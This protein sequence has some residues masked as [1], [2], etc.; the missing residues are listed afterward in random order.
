MEQAIDGGFAAP[1]FDAQAIFRAVMDAMA[2]PGTIQPV[3]ALTQPPATLSATAGAVALTLCDHDTPLWLDTPL[4][5]SA[6]AKSWLAF[7]SGAPL[8]AT[9]ADAHFA[10]VANPANL[11]ALENFAQGTQEYPD[12]STTLILQVESLT[13]GEPL[14]LK[15]PGIETLAT[16]APTPLPRHFVEQWK[17]N[18]ARFPRGVDIIL[19]AP[20]GVACLPRTTRIKTLET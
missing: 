17:Q 8:A 15:G 19:A 12:R 11:M 4:Q 5:V 13:A 10:L 6:A 20:D 9:A 18:G 3:A 16:I 14:E 1:V 2:R 7:H